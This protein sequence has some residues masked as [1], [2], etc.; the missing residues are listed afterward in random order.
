MSLSLRLDVRQ[1]QTLVMTPQLQQ[2]IKLLQLGNL[3]LATDVPGG[4]EQNPFLERQEES[5]EA[6][7]EPLAEP[8]AAEPAREGALTGALDMTPHQD[9]AE[10]SSTAPDEGWT[11]PGAEQGSPWLD[12]TSVAPGGRSRS[13][14]FDDDRFDLEAR[15]SRP[16][17]LREHLLEQ[18][19]IDLPPGPER[20]VGMHLIDLVDEA[21]YLTDDLG[22]VAAR[23]GCSLAEV[24][25]VLARLQHFDPPG[26][27]ARSVKECLALQLR[28]VDRL[29]PAMQALLDHLDLLAHADL[30]RL[31]RACGVLPEDL[32][33][34]VAEIKALNPKPGLA[35]AHDV[36]ETMVPDVLVLPVA[37][38]GWRVELNAAT[39]PKVLVNTAYYAELYGRTV[40]RR[41]REYLAERLQSASWLVKA[42][43]QRARTLLR[44][45]EAVV[46]RQLG[47]LNHGVQQLRPMVLRDIA[48]ATDMHES[49][50]SRATADKYVATPRGNFAFQYFFSNALPATNGEASH[51][52]E[53]IRQQV[54]IMIEREDP[55]RVLSDDQIVAAL[56]ATGVSIARRTVAKYRE[57]LAIPSSVERRRS[58][59]LRLA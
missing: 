25:A 46:E 19:Q 34:M 58:K 8:P 28:D 1:S 51:A 10:A 49:T 20:I 7:S 50:I 18:L 32:P 33:E 26:V 14:D 17:T 44:V 16:R 23:L 30:D 54:K 27:L 57:S 15:L 2:A 3:D 29:D 59:A 53:A 13:S 22:E 37:G 39:L 31:Q 42:L 43:D 9:V 47:F 24:E 21:G 6:S 45:A 41:A 36:V 35:F 11:D 40:D 12:V 52:A 38:G 48:E 55:E 56:R 4:L 5:G